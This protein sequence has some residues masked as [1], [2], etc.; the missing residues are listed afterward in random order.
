MSIP[1]F[2]EIALCSRAARESIGCPDVRTYVETMPGVDGEFVQCHGSGGRG[3]RVTGILEATDTAP[4]G[5]HEA[6]KESLRTLQALADGATVASYVGTDGQSYG[7][8]ILSSVRTTAALDV[9]R[10]AGGYRAIV[11]IEAVLHQLTP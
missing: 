8:C 2:N 3:I 10:A 9:C 1:T 7:N 5:A 11:A 6:L 4:A